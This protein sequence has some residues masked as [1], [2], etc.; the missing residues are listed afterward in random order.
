MRS[1]RTAVLMQRTARSLVLFRV[2][3]QLSQTG[4]RSTG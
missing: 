4:T 3:L 2:G 1:G